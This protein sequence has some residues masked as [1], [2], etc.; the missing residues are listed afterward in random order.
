M[1]Y[2]NA[3]G[4]E[5]SLSGPIQS[6]IGNSIGFD[7][8]YGTARNDGFH[9]KSIGAPDQLI[10]GAGDDT[11]TLWSASD[12]VERAGEGNDTVISYL[13][14]GTV[15]AD[16]VENLVLMGTNSRF[17]IGNALDNILKAGIVGAELQGG[18]GNDV[19]IGGAGADTMV[20]RAGEGSDVIIDFDVARDNI[21]LGGFGFN[22]FT[23]VK[24]AMQ[25]V[26]RDVVITLD[27]DQTLTLRDTKIGALSARNFEL[28]VD[29][30]KFSLLFDESFD[31]LVTQSQGG[32]WKTDFGNGDATDRVRVGSNEIYVDVDFA[33]TAAKALGINPFSVQD[34]ILTIT[35]APS[36]D[37][38]KYLGGRD[39]TTGV[40]S[41]IGTFSQQYGYFEMRAA[42]PEGAGFLP[43]FWLKP[44][45]GSWPPE[46]DV[47]ESLGKD[48]DTIYLS[49]HTKETGVHTWQ[50][51]ATH[52]DASEMHTYALNWTKDEL[53]WY[54]DGTEVAR[55]KSTSD[56]AQEFYVMI[57]LGVGGDWAGKPDANTGTGQMKV[58]YVR[59]YANQDT[60]S[61]TDRGQT[62]FLDQS[63][64]VEVS[65]TSGAN[66]MRGT[67]HGD[68]MTG[69]DGNDTYIVNHVDDQIVE[70]NNNGK[71]GYDIVEASVNYT[72]S[73]NVEELR[74]VGAATKGTGNNGNNLLI[75]NDHA[76][77]LYGMRG[78]DRLV[79]KDGDD[80]L[81]GGSGIDTMEGGRGN[82]S[83]YVDQAGDKVIER[84]GEGRDTVYASVSYVM[85][86]NVERLVLTGIA[87]INATGG[88]GDDELV[89]NVG[90]N[91]LD[92]GKGAD[93]MSGGDGDDTYVVD[94]AGDR[95][96]EWGNDGK[97][98]IDTVEASID[99]QLG[100]Q[101]ERL[102]LTGTA[103]VGVGN[104]LDNDLYGNDQDN[105]LYGLAGNDRLYGG[106]GKDLLDGGV[107][108]DYMEGGDG[109]DTYYVDNVGDRIVE[110][111]NNGR[112]GND[113]VISS[114]SYTLAAYVET[115]RLTGSVGLEGTGNN[116][117]NLI[118]GTTGAD[119]LRGMGGNDILY[120]EDDHDTIDGGTGADTMYGGDGNDTFYVDNVNDQVIE[121]YNGGRGG[122]DRVFASVN[123]TIGDNVEDLTLTGAAN[124]TGT[125]NIHRNV[126]TGNSGNNQLYGMGGDDHLIGG[127]GNDLLD[128]GTGVDRME[129]GTGDDTYYVDDSADQVIEL[130]GEG[131]DVV[132]ASASFTLGDNVE[133]LR[134]TGSANIDGTGNA[135]DNVING[136]DGNNRLF[137]GAG[138]D[139]LWG[140]AGNDWLDGGTG[141]DIMTG[142]DGNDTYVVDN[143]GDQVIEWTG[144]AGG[145]D[146]VRSSISYTLASTLENLTL[147]GT[148]AIDAT[149][150]GLDNIIIGNSA[151]NIIIGG[152]GNDRLT[153]GGGADTFLFRGASGND[154]ITDFDGNDKIDLSGWLY[155]GAADL[156]KIA[157]T[158]SA[159]GAV[160]TLA[161][162]GSI[163]LLGVTAHEL[164]I[165]SSGMVYHV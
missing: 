37:N 88:A 65:G 132:F 123:Y 83:Y 135:L 109:D 21:R 97:G 93:T 15:L 115:L 81:D 25:Q 160:I 17:G 71:G 133:E 74:L 34:G 2:I 70:W 101:L 47:M 19:L 95:I 91:R 114:V 59:V 106:A 68:K 122:Y 144:A 158:D 128:G 110:W 60:V 58:D 150:N 148:A 121:W 55:V 72:L 104:E 152:G 16:N 48:P 84:A 149:G 162:R 35:A 163:Q 52:I 26:G 13:P 113:T 40:L 77:E 73:E 12:V 38:A 143:I 140:G 18:G 1:G 126:L 90:A 27:D 78:D 98:G 118:V 159:D 39:Y 24:S 41:T 145:I 139:R 137:G 151:A 116:D 89:G 6:W 45:N 31:T 107:G 94:N 61:Y 138:N 46:L 120:G 7:V 44:K 10:G 165:N 157:I 161:G 23:Q 154:V 146:T 32:Y 142:G 42:M 111:N 87:A 62:T 155:Q 141:A 105:R 147:T 112:G 11:Y 56:L 80:L 100:A 51:Q 8:Q 85:P 30:S 64:G 14:N 29:R 67:I 103:I 129:G 22:D 5:L 130:A 53:V 63:K 57:N 82:D 33:G 28:D 43:A 49:N 99:Y 156:A 119:V 153:G 127:A 66:L 36:G 131:R 86:A 125:G 102:K 76:S 75:G 92:G 50:N 69:G 54:I 124:L 164:S 9:G 79:G 20:V 136:N 96:I 3:I 117:A 108:A 134:L 4:R